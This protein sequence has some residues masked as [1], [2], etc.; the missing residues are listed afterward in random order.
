M[1]KIKI[2]NP[3]FITYQNQILTIDI[4]GG[5]DTQQ[6]HNMT[7]TLRITHQN[8]PP[9]RTTID[10]YNEQQT[11][12]LIRKICD[13]W[14]LKLI[15]VSHTLYDLIEQLEN[16]RLENLRHLPKTQPYQLS[17]Q[18]KKQALAYLKSKNLIQKIIHDLNQTGIIGEN[19]N[20]LILFLTAASHKYQNPFSAICLAKTGIGKSYMLQKLTQCM[21]EGAYSYHTRISPNALYYFRSQEIDHKALFIEDMEWT[22]QMLI[23]LATLQ[24]QGKLVKTRTTKDKNGMFHSTTFE[25]QGKLCLIGCA[26]SDK[27]YENLSLPFLMLH[28]NHSAAQDQA[29]MQYQKKRKAGLIDTRQITQA[30]KRL[31]DVVATL[32]NVSVINPYATLIELPPQI[33]HPRKSM[34]LLLNFIEIITYFFQYQRAQ[35]ADPDT[36]EVFI[37]T[38]P[39]DIELAFQ[40][41]KQPLLRRADELTTPARGFYNWLKHYLDQAK[42]QEFTALDLRR[43]KPIHPRTLNR[44]LNELK[45]FGYIQITGGNKYRGYRYRITGLGDQNHL[46]AQIEQAL[47]KNLEKIRKAHQKQQHKQ[48]QKQTGQQ[49][50]QTETPARKPVSQNTLSD[51]SPTTKPVADK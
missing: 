22:S 27:N 14:Q 20:A 1:E 35:K 51:N 16:Y 2:I 17:D 46:N 4:L 48:Q 39:D 25:V 33:R 24:T 10:L 26:Y 42:I 9:M 38:H 19:N 41:L 15:D 7:A 23:P 30:Q 47:Q 37:E 36:G 8:Y 28:L 21:P 3:H 50:K 13:K 18:D 29:V 11:E 44:Y 49:Q 32:E 31:K 40:L 5:I 12:R 45:L 43:E 6:L 34:L